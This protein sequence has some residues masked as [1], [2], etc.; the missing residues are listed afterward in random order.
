[1]IIGY[2]NLSVV[3]TYLGLMFS[4]L[5]ISM[6]MSNSF[7]IDVIYILMILSGVCDLFDGSVAR[8]IKRN[9]DEKKYGVEIDSLC[10]IVNFV[11]FPSILA[12]RLN[13]YSFISFIIIFVFVL[14]GI[15]RLAYYNVINTNIRSDFYIGMP[16]TFSSIFFPYIHIFFINNKLYNGLSMKIDENVIILFAMFVL[17]LLFVVR[18]RIKK[19]KI[20]GLIFLTLLGIIAGVLLCL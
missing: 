19:P 1:M 9:S 10:D 5:G 11:I 3:L 7:D 6:L 13:S 17:S 12:L 4:T 15:V 14:S 18:I 8:K 16:V 2:W 20:K